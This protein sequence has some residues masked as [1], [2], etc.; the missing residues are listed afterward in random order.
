MVM[1]PLLFVELSLKNCCKMLVYVDQVTERLQF[2]FE[3]I[4]REHGLDYQFTND[5]RVFETSSGVRRLSYS[6][7]D[8]DNVLPVLPAALLFDETIDPTL[9]VAKTQWEGVPML[10]VNGIADPF[11][12]VFY[13][14]SRY[15][16]YTFPGR[17][18]HDRFEARSSILYQ[19]GW[20][21]VQVVEQWVEAIVR[22]YCPEQLPGLI[23]NRTVSIIPS[24]DIDHTYAYKW[25]GGWRKWLSVLKDY[26]KKDTYRLQER[27][28]VLSGL[29]TDPYDTFHPISSIAQRFPETRI[30][31]HLGDFAEYDRNASWRDPRHQRLIRTM[32]TVSEIGLHP[33]YASN[34]S[35]KRLAEE[36][37]RLTSIL[38][39]PVTSSRQHFLKLKLPTTYRR[40]IALGFT[41]DYTM[42][43]ADQPGFRAGT[44][45]PFYFFDLERN[46]QTDYLLV[47]F[48]YMDGT[49]REYLD[50]SIEE[51][52]TIITALAN[53]VKRYGGNFCCIWHNETIGTAPK[54]SGWDTVLDH[55]LAQFEH[56]EP[57]I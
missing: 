8:F 39:K 26:V 35:D 30:F 7:L 12:A 5:R 49:F 50:C 57:L 2:T 1:Q 16:E 44:A 40:L 46:V 28:L 47:P 22:N 42:G 36:H 10:S 15:E 51:S 38:G 56:D 29:Q 34:L 11:A 32:G 3:F 14:L 55:T 43:Y 18:H 25:K 48:T 9:K 31:W 20:L 54:W 52:K 21:Q 37:Q 45:H 33:S 19:S 17:D 4:F 23:A 6:E 41:T 24:F 13:V 27:K 53:E